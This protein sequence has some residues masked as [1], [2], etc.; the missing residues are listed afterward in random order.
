M[1]L[2]VHLFIYLFFSF[3]FF[4]LSLLLHDE[5]VA[6]DY[7]SFHLQSKIKR[8]IIV[9]HSHIC[10][11]HVA[12]HKCIRSLMY[13][14]QRWQ[15]KENVLLQA[16]KFPSFN[17]VHHKINSQEG[18]TGCACGIRR[19]W[20]KNEFQWNLIDNCLHSF[21]RRNLI[22]LHERYSVLDGTWA[23]HFD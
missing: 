17:W 14:W 8:I 15:Q 12:L 7:H 20:L 22:C 19:P 11:I 23:H 3:F 21:L 4:S 9:I 1:L 10:S 16:C 18:C 6:F 13:G 2:F 5:F